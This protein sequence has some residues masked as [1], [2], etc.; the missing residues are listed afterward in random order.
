LVSIDTMPA[1][2]KKQEKFFRVVAAAKE[3]K[4]G[5]SK[6]AK[7]V[8]EQ[9]SKKDIKKYTKAKKGAPEEAPKKEGKKVK[10]NESFCLQEEIYKLL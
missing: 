6:K 9:M 3:G 8:S 2:S 10:A 5:I 7:D 4:K 1:V